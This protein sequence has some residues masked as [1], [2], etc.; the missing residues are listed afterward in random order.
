M[1]YSMTAFGLGS[2]RCEEY[3]VTTEIR[4]VNN[5]FLDCSVRLPRAY[6]YLEEKIKGYLTQKGI[7]RGKIDVSVSVE[8]LSSDIASVRLDKGLA[9]AYI[10]ALGELRDAFSLRDDISVM[11]VAQFEGV[12]CTEKPEHQAEKDWNMILPSLSD[13]VDMF[14]AA[15][16]S[17]GERI[18]KDI[19]AKIA[20]ISSITPRIAEYS[21]T[22]VKTKRDRL[23]ER[24][25]KL[26]GEEGIEPDEGRLLTECALFADRIA[27]DEELVRL[28]SHFDAFYEIL[29]AGGAAGRKLDFL[30]Q[31]MNRETN[32]IGSKCSNIEISKLVVEIKSELEKIREQIQNIE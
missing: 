3:N 15:R 30:L 17:E 27:I 21:D 32:T 8:L 22:D 1:I 5:R 2:T 20:N 4:S 19:R 16:K 29:G 12:L 31:E 25:K 26:M 14:I 13:A 24:I 28:S 6:S 18:E 11:R 7:T 23:T 9:E 10:K